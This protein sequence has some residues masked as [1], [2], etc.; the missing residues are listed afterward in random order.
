MR[1]LL[2]R[3]REARVVVGDC[4]VGAIGEG[5]LALV[6]IG[7]ADTP[8]DADRMAL[9]VVGLR[10]FDDPGGRLNQDVRAAG[11]GILSVSQFTLYANAA[12]GRRPSFA[13]AAPSGQAEPLW[14]RFNTG[15]RAAGVEVATGVFGAEMLVHLVNWGPVTL[16]LESGRKGGR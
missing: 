5:L 11:G 7:V 1:V 4:V 15:L 8:E 10:V 6:G 3:V 16:L 9:K 13:G 2:Q 12:K 14:Q